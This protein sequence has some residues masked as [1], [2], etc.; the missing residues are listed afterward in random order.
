MFIVAAPERE[1]S[2]AVEAWLNELQSL[3]I[4]TVIPSQTLAEANEYR[5]MS[6]C[7][8]IS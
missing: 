6:L 8:K 1:S 7:E 2:D 4:V 3:C 5:Q